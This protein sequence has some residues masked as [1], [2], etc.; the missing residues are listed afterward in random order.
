MVKL[1]INDVKAKKSYKRDLDGNPF[2]HK[3]IGDV[4]PG[5][6]FGFKGYEFKITG[7]T[8]KDGFP[9]KPDLNSSGRRKILILTAANRKEKG[10]RQRINIH[11]NTVD[12]GVSQ[13]NLKIEKY[14]KETIPKILGLEVEE[15]K[16]EAPVEV[17]A[18]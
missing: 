14:G 9:M 7:G 13:I 1:T 11:G 4:V 6:I 12:E 10:V 15:K 5:D 16:E 18:E 17:K 2:L 8:D 3:K